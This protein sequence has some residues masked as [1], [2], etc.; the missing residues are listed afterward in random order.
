[1]LYTEV[2]DVGTTRP[3]FFL[4]QG[5]YQ[6]F[7]AEA[8][9]G[10]GITG[11]FLIKGGWELMYD[12]YGG[13]LALQLNP[14]INAQTRQF[15]WVQPICQDLLG[16]KVALRTPLDEVTFSLSSYTGDAKFRV[17]DQIIEGYPFEDRYTLIGTSVEYLTDQWWLRSEYLTQQISSKIEIDVVYFETAYKLNEHW[18][19]AARYEWADFELDTPETRDTPKAILEHEEIVLGL[20]YWMNVNLV[21]K[22]SYHMVNGN[23]FAM[24]E[25]PEEYMVAYQ[26]GFDEHTNLFVFGV[27]FSF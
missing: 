2:Y 15:E 19:V 4:P 9:K 5:V 20:N 17:D 24:P 3:L 23:R 18:Q 12:V 14:A 25:T 8:Y 22:L 10:A 16:G 6:E 13:Q 26:T 11:S 1:M 7:A 21:F 27:Q